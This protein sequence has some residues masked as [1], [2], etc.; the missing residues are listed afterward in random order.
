MSKDK[1]IDIYISL[2]SSLTDVGDFLILK[3]KAPIYV[4]DPNSDTLK[5]IILSPLLCPQTLGNGCARFKSFS[6]LSCF[7]LIYHQGSTRMVEDLGG[8]GFSV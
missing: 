3:V 5:S 6:L 1:L 2:F 7:P 8:L 4:S